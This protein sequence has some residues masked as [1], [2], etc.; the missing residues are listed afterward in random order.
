[1]NKTLQLLIVDDEPLARRLSH[2]YLA[3]YVDINIVGECTNGVEAV[4]AIGT[5]APDL[6]LL[7]IFMPKLNGLEVLELTGRTHG[8]IFTTAYDQY[9]L[10]AFDLHAVDYLLKP[11]SQE[12][13]DEAIARARKLLGTSPT[14]I[15]ELIADT[16]LER[17]VVRDRGQINIIPLA[18][19]DYIEAQDDYICIHW[20]GKSILKTQ[21]LSALETQLDGHEFVRIHRSFIVKLSAIKCLERISKDAQVAVLHS[22]TKL[23]VS[24]AGHE[25]LKNILQTS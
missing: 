15:P 14:T 1:M 13:F 18:D 6:I 8:V 24:R 2:E 25:R 23:P 12:R 17:L 5:L 22:G 9:A 19:V 10:K 7:D 16:K 11:F 4:D 21:S 3:K 20:N